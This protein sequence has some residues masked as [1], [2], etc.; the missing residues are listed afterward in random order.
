MK[1]AEGTRCYAFISFDNF[2]SSD[3][4]IAQMNGQFFAGRPITVQYALKKDSKTERHGSAAERI[5]AARNP[6][7]GRFRFVVIIF[8]CLFFS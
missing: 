7:V 4:A 8:C 2:E 1:D 6:N 3:A 5:L